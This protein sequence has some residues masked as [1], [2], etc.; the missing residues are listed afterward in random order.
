M[1]APGQKQGKRPPQACGAGAREAWGAGAA[2]GRGLQ[3]AGS[4]L[5]RPLAADPPDPFVLPGPEGRKKHLEAH[6]GLSPDSFVPPKV[7]LTLRPDF[8]VL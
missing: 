2:L 6:F 7:F 1:R 8:F 4:G 5:R 3:E